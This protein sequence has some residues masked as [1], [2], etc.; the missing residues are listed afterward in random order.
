MI[1]I[2]MQSGCALKWKNIKSSY[3]YYAPYFLFGEQKMLL[4]SMFVSVKVTCC[5]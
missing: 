3:I 2:K 5:F 4:N 1:K